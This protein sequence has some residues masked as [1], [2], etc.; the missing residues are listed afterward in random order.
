MKYTV[1]VAETRV[2]TWNDETGSL[3]LSPTSLTKASFM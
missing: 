1:T 3:Y 2:G